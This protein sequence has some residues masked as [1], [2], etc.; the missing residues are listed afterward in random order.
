MTHDTHSDIAWLIGML[1]ARRPLRVLDLGCADCPEGEALVAAGADLVGIDLDEA[2]IVAAHDRLPGASFA[3]GDAADTLRGHEA[4]F[5]V[6]L[7]RRPDLAVQPDRWRQILATAAACLV[8][9]GQVLVSTPGP[10]EA[11]LARQWLT[12][13]GFS[14]VDGTA[15]DAAGERFVVTASEPAPRPAS[16][17]PPLPAGVVRWGGDEEAEVC[18][19]RTG[20]CGPAGG[21]TKNRLEED[22]VTQS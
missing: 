4:S 1:P 3:C 10:E 12:E 2:A 14:R 7:A 17:G 6:V 21:T 16:P 18:D 5:D 20:T 15:L 19:V 9:D 11:H 8:P 13:A 22:H